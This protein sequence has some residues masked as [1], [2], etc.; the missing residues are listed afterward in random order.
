MHRIPLVIP[1]FLLACLPAA[2]QT[3][4]ACEI[5]GDKLSIRVLVTNPYDQE[6]HCQ[7]NCHFNAPGGGT[8]SSSCGKTVP[9]K[10]ADFLLCAQERQN[11]GPYGAMLASSN[12]EC[13][14]PLSDAERQKE[15]EDDDALIEKLQKDGQ[16]ALKRLQK[17][18]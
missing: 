5:S 13:T 18:N 14:K 15:D 9:A 7:V 10:A 12:A 3:K 17:G 4:F 1:F 8:I 2:A 11:K 6:T 16:D